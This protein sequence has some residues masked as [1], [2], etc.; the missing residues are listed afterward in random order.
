MHLFAV[1]IKCNTFQVCLEMAIAQMLCCCLFASY[2]I[3]DPN[4]Y[5]KY[6]HTYMQYYSNINGKL[7]Y[8]FFV[9]HM[10]NNIWLASSTIIN[11][12]WSEQSISIQHAQ[13]HGSNFQLVLSVS[14]QALIS[15]MWYI[16]W[17]FFFSLPE[18][19][20][21][22]SI[23]DMVCLYGIFIFFSILCNI[24]MWNKYCWFLRCMDWLISINRF[25]VFPF[26]SAMW[27]SS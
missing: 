12:F 15:I 3:N 18:K 7:F 4:I 11:L 2:S 26:P 20:C 9:Q 5:P 1:G 21:Y 27:F 17:S 8:I 10:V 19:Q 23:I 6:E 22:S 24:Y 16:Q 25:L 13:S 14:E